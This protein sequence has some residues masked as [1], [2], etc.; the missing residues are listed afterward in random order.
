VLAGIS[1]GQTWDFTLLFD[2]VEDHIDH[3]LFNSS[4]IR[5]NEGTQLRSCDV[6]PICAE[7]WF[8]SYGYRMVM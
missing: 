7:L 6:L 2:R 5:T 3:S 8:H 1:T 4:F